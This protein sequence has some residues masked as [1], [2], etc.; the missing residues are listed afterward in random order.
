MNIF[1]NKDLSFENRYISPRIRQQLR[2]KYAKKNLYVTISSS[3]SVVVTSIPPYLVTHILVE[4]D[5]CESER[6]EW[7]YPYGGDL[8]FQMGQSYNKIPY[9]TRLTTFK[10]TTGEELLRWL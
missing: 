3:A 9:V 4:D 7:N 5:R 1:G 6:L 2:K 8:I 10:V